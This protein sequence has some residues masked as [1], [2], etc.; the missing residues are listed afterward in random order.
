MYTGLYAKKSTRC[1]GCFSHSLCAPTL[2]MC[3][4]NC[5]A[6]VS[7]AAAAGGNLK[8]MLYLKDGGGG[9]GGGGEGQWV[10]LLWIKTF[11]MDHRDGERERERERKREREREGEG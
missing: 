11:E 8:P 10:S 1:G 6:S 4:R 5:S 3:Q 9:G 7:A 2:N